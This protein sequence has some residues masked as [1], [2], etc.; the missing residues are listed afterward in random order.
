GQAAAVR[1]LQARLDVLHL[2][3]DAGDGV[4]IDVGDDVLRAPGAVDLDVA[5]AL[6]AHEDV[7][8]L[9][10]LL[11][12]E[13]EILAVDLDDDLPADAGDGLLHPILDRLAEVVLHAGP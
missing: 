9:L 4:A 7:L 8:D 13:A 3:P 5:G 10:E 12:H 11:L 1:A 2:E 6:R